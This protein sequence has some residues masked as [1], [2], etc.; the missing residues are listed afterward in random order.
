MFSDD[1]GPGGG[2]SKLKL[3]G[4]ASARTSTIAKTS[5]TVDVG[6]GDP[7]LTAD[8]AA[9]EFREKQ[10]RGMNK[11]TFETP[12]KE[13]IDFLAGQC[14]S[15]LDRE[16]ISQLFSNDHYKEKF[17]LLGLSS[18]DSGITTAKDTE[19]WEDIK[20]KYICNSDLILKYLTIR[21]FDTNTSMLI[22]CLELLEH[23]LQIFDEE[24]Y[25]LTEYEASAFLPFFIG[26]LGDNK[27]TMRVRI[28]EICKQLS[29]VYPIGKMFT[30]LMAGLASK[31]SRT[32]TECLD[33]VTYLIQRAG[34]LDVANPTKNFPLIAAQIADRDAA[35]RNAAINAITQGYL[36][37]GDQV[38]KLVGR[39]PDKDKSLLEEKFKRLPPPVIK[40]KEQPP[41]PS[42]IASP[43]S[44]LQ[45]TSNPQQKS[46]EFRNSTVEM[47]SSSDSLRQIPQNQFRQSAPSFAFNSNN[48]QTENNNIGFKNNNIG[49]KKRIQFRF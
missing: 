23:L 9:K 21:F 32:R 31:N 13:L 29:K 45:F 46:D 8:P 38:Y 42:R 19:N 35:V 12:R 20:M 47:K 18:L 30:Y 34:T 49:F 22:K 17:F 48:M 33:E 43:P 41:P 10:D 7:I 27:E 37:V 1:S 3:P 4:G 6:G 36:L 14:E 24:R 44:K 40:P 5:S 39:I 2:I 16:I 26:K 28:K 15:N 11:W 25:K